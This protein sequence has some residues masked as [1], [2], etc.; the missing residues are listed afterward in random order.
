MHLADA[1]IQC[2]LQ[3]QQTSLYYTGVNMQVGLCCIIKQLEQLQHC[4]LLTPYSCKIITFLL[5]QS[6]IIFIQQEYNHIPMLADLPMSVK[7]YF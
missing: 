7:Q 3:C 2:D 1:L 4:A 6:F 5:F